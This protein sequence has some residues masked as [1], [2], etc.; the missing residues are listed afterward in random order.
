MTW[1]TAKE[2]LRQAE[3]DLIREDDG[4]DVERVGQRVDPGHAQLVTG[5][6]IVVL[7]FTVKGDIDDEGSA[8]RQDVL[9]DLLHEE[10]HQIVDQNGLEAR[11]T[12]A[13]ESHGEGADDKGGRNEVVPVVSVK[14]QPDR[15]RPERGI[16]S[17]HF[18]LGEGVRGSFAANIADANLV[19]NDVIICHGKHNRPHP[20]HNS[21]EVVCKGVLQIDEPNRQKAKNR[22]CETRIIRATNQSV[23]PRRHAQTPPAGQ[24]PWGKVSER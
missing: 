5:E 16:V 9:F 22:G 6:A 18:F 1:K 7:S 4:T 24:R 20:V 19:E 14:G 8:S 15:R 23:H 2:A 17:V 13:E 10:C 21:D 3:P 12:V 11:K